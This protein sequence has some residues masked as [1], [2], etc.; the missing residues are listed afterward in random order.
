[1]HSHYEEIVAWDALAM[2]YVE[3]ADYRRLM[4]LYHSCAPLCPSED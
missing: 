4:F 3:R 2:S 1:M